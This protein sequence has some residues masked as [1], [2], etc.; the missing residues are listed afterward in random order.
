MVI[1]WEAD[2]ILPSVEFIAIFE[3]E[4]IG[5]LETGCSA[6]LDDRAGSWRRAELLHLKEVEASRMSDACENGGYKKSR[7]DKLVKCNAPNFIAYDI[8]KKLND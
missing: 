1:C 2:L 3:Q 7:T 5:G 8:H 6:I 4:L